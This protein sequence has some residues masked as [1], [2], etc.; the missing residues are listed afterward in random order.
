M[1]WGEPVSFRTNSRAIAVAEVVRFDDGGRLLHIEGFRPVGIDAAHDIAVRKLALLELIAQA[2]VAHRELCRVRVALA[3]R[4]PGEQID[5]AEAAARASFLRAF[6]ATDI[7]A[8][9]DIAQTNSGQFVVAATWNRTPTAVQ[10][11]EGCLA[12][13]RAAYDQFITPP[14][15]WRHIWNWARFLTRRIHSR[16]QSRACS[17]PVSLS[18]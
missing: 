4:A 13:E 16:K 14:P 7:H 17:L 6:G 1:H 9:P 18:K 3:C 8:Q 10:M 2:L 5:V 12:T 15:F 11:L